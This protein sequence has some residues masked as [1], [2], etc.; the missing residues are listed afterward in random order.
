LLKPLKVDRQTNMPEV[1]GAICAHPTPA[2]PPKLMVSMLTKVS[3]EKP[4]PPA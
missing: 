4:T 2:G 1:E 3:E